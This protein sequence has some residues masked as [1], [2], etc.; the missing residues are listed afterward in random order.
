MKK[1]FAIA[2]L[3]IAAVVLSTGHASAWWEHFCGKC[4]YKIKVT[5]KQYNAFSPFC[6]D[7]VPMGACSGNGGCPAAYSFGG[8]AGYGGGYVN[9]LPAAADLAGGGHVIY[10]N[11]PGG[12][13][14]GPAT[15]FPGAGFRIPPGVAAQNA[16]TWGQPMPNP[17]G[18]PSYYP[19]PMGYAPSNGLGR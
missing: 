13:M 18:V 11:A 12:I 1:L 2:T 5:C 10:P 8:E 15:G 7:G 19:G 16:P 9:E 4:H 3:S 17:T 14:Q 6:C